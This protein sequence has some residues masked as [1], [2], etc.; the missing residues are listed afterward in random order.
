[1]LIFKKGVGEMWKA[2]DETRIAKSWK[3]KLNW[4]Y[5]VYN[6]ILFLI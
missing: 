5:R 2:R 3:D 4:W 6:T 1:M